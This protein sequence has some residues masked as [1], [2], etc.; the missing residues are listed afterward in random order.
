[1]EAIIK[2]I[3]QEFKPLKKE[4]GLRCKHTNNSKQDVLEYIKPFGLNTNKHNITF[5]FILQKHENSISFTYSFICLKK[6]CDLKE[7]YS[8]FDDVNEYPGFNSDDVKKIKDLYQFDVVEGIIQN[9]VPLE[10]QKTV[11]LKVVSDN[12]ANIIDYVRNQNQ[13]FS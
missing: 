6:Y 7:S 3:K 8:F 2:Q 9:K 4:H 10:D 1:M 13:Q 5:K 12:L 11:I